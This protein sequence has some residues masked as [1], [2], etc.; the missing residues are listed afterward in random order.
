[1]EKKSYKKYFEQTK[2]MLFA[3]IGVII[4]G[5]ILYFLNDFVIH[6]W[7]IYQASWLI[8]VAGVVC[9]ICHFAI[10]IRDGAVDEYA[11]TFHK[12]LEEQLETFV[13]ETE[14]HKKIN[15]VFDYTSGGYELWDKDITKLVLGGDNTPRCEQ[16]GGGALTY[17]PDT[18]YV[19]A[20]NVNLINGE[21]SI[22][23]FHAPLSEINS[24]ELVDRSYTKEIK[25]KTRYI[26][27][28]VIEINTDN[29]KIAFTVHPDA[30]T[31]EAVSKVKRTAETKKD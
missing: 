13:T 8:M 6:E 12:D 30:M 5:I 22:T 20:G 23:K 11:A 15:R 26:E 16:Y 3:G 1:M 4:A 9:I 2:K 25:K 10:R 29:A 18:L 14:K 24:I 7:Q 27:C 17:T 31:D 21:V 19:A 28:F